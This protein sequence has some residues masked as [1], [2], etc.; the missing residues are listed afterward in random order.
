MLRQDDDVLKNFDVDHLAYVWYLIHFELMRLYFDGE[1]YL[2]FLSPQLGQQ[3][4]LE[5]VEDFGSTLVDGQSAILD[6]AIKEFAT[7]IF[8][9]TKG[10][11]RANAH[12]SASASI[13][14]AE[15]ECKS[16]NGEDNWKSRYITQVSSFIRE[17]N[18][19]AISTKYWQISRARQLLSTNAILPWARQEHTLPVRNVFYRE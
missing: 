9:H 14:T 18:V 7:C 11:I 2:Q 16:N 17:R 13:P 10:K 1:T 3:I 15:S 8:E 6:G 12:A 19:Y 5:E 4:Q